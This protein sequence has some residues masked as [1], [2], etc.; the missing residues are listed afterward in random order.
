[1][2]AQDAYNPGQES[3]SVTASPNI[4]TVQAR[5]DPNASAN[6]LIAALGSES[7]QSGIANF[8]HTYEK[9]KLED[10]TLKIDSYVQ[11]FA[12]DHQ[13][14]AVSQAQVR[15]RFP[16][17]VPAIAARI[18]ESIGKKQGMLDIAPVIAE[19]NG[20][21][22]LR[23]DTTQRAAFV[24]KK[25]EELFR[26]I[27]QGNDFYAAGVVS[28]MD[29]AFGQEELKWQAQTSAYHT[30][31]QKT[32]LSDEA[33]AAFQ[34]EDPKA[35]LAS[36]DSNWGK[37][38]SLNNVER[39]KVYVDSVIKLSAIS[40]NP[41]ILD[42]IPQAYLNVDSKAAINK[43]R[44]AITGQQ[45]AKFTKDKEFAT[46]QRSE[47]TRKGK[48]EILTNLAGNGNVDPAK[49]LNDPDLHAFAV[50]Q[51]ETP[52]IPEATSKAAVQSF[53]LNILSAGNVESLG[54]QDQ[55]INSVLAMRGKMNPKEMAALVDEIP[56]L[57][58]GAVLMNDPNI[59][60]AFTDHIGFRLDDL[61]KST[62]PKLQLLLGTANIRGNATAMF[63]GEIRGNFEAAYTET[64]RWP[65]GVEARKITDA[66]VAKV[67]SYI[68]YQTSLKALST[69]DQP[70]PTAP[71]VNPRSVSGKVTQPTPSG[72]PKGVTLIK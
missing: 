70:P 10:Q 58:E 13:G 2:A 69:P 3:A 61:S 46:W 15:A 16:E 65:I 66:A 67:S 29:R 72:L 56:K 18:A 7:T 42:K 43:A 64:G 53:R 36:I 62:N 51:M 59:R 40:D 71:K 38:S 8:Q 34:S 60:R 24:A 63:E 4:Q 31:V 5:F 14:G 1:M 33:V 41:T 9:K 23:L 22:S 27:P 19:I 21:D 68:D 37:S 11:Q 48:V 35:A 50:A 12:N 25:R 54:P 39:N 30:E 55:I 44:I 57:M 49:Y 26:A 20:S 47:A 32:S 45:W 17:T 52:S 28:A 6:S